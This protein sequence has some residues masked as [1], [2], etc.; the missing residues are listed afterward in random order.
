M[1]SWDSE[2]TEEE[3]DRLIDKI[4]T[5][6][7][8]RG[9]ETPAILFLEMHKPLSFVVSQGMVVGSPL[10][11]PFVGFDNVQI[12]TRLMENRENVELLIRRI[13][14]LAAERQ[15]QKRG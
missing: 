8:K 4:A 9:L 7:V 5:G 14:G 1:R 13:E 11:A 12:A 2:V 3:R 10:I 6:V 15:L